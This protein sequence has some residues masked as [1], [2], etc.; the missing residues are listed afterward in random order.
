MKKKR[1]V[2]SAL[3]CCCD[4]LQKN[5]KRSHNE[6][7]SSLDL[8]IISSSSPSP[9]KVSLPSSMMVLPWQIVLLTLAKGKPK[10][11]CPSEIGRASCRERV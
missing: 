8:A 9:K 11:R 3:F 5:Q 4:N 6:A 1:A 2:Y 10:V 7:A